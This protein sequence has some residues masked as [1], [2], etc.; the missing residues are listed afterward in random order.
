MSDAAAAADL[1]RSAL[2]EGGY[3]RRVTTRREFRRAVRLP[4]SFRFFISKMRLSPGS[5]LLEVGI[6]GG[7]KAVPFAAHGFQVTGIDSSPE[8]LSRSRQL[9]DDVQSIGG[10]DLP[11]CLIEGEFPSD[12]IDGLFDCVYQVGV[13][14]HIFDRA[15]RI[16]F[17]ERMVALA[18]PGGRVL[19]VV[20]NGMHPLRSVMRKEKLG[21]YSVPEIDYSAELLRS[22]L[23]ESGLLN[24]VV[25]PIAV[26]GYR[27]IRGSG[28]GR[29]AQL[30]CA[31]VP[32]IPMSFLYRHCGA[33][34]AIGEK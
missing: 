8:A 7:S 15:A 32:R 20:P 33:L 5:S 12:P 27:A 6:G 13:V 1:W 21:G 16:S 9:V 17:H 3:D 18:K 2:V 31:G 19:S 29:V 11:I 22:E 26:L 30:A 25:Y 14:E 24:V 34:A 28:A 10:R 4:R 23:T